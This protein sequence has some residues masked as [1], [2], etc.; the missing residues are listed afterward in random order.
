MNCYDI[1]H[2]IHLSPSQVK[3][4]ITDEHFREFVERSERYPLPVALATFAIA[5]GYG[6]R[7]SYRQRWT[8]RSSS[9]RLCSRAQPKEKFSLAV[10]ESSEL[11]LKHRWRGDCMVL[12]S[13]SISLKLQIQFLIP[14]RFKLFNYSTTLITGYKLQIVVQNKRGHMDVGCSCS[15]EV[16]MSPST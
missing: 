6:T 14:C 9:S 1:R 12:S 7:R 11:S 4:W 15:N 16:W 8:E 10:K 13:L 5:L 3:M 2:E